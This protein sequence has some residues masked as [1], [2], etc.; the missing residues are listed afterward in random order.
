M[1]QGELGEAILRRQNVRCNSTGT[2]ISGPPGP[3][4]P[5]AALPWGPAGGSGFPAPGRA[6]PPRLPSLD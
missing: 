2:L 5:G 3:A 4:R 1:E 6:P